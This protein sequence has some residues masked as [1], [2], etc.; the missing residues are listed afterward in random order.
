MDRAGPRLASLLG[1]FFFFCGNVVFGIGL[2]NTR[3]S[4]LC[5]LI[6]TEPDL[7]HS[8]PLWADI[9]TYYV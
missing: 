2:E 4:N 6:V 3:K 1:A 5:F 8:L 7:S 9:D